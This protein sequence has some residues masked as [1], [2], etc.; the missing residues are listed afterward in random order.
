MNRLGAASSCR[1]EGARGGATAKA[2]VGVY[3]TRFDCELKEST[4]H[5][6]ILRWFSIVSENIIHK[7]AAENPLPWRPYSRAPSAVCHPV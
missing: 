6:Y 4:T 7:D 5:A 1:P 3:F 2:G